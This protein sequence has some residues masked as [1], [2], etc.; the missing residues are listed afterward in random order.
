MTTL[1]STAEAGARLGISARQAQRLVRAGRLER[2]GIDRIDYASVVHLMSQ[3]RGDHHRV[4]DEQTAWAAIA[5][6]SGV[7]TQWLGQAQRSRLKASLRSAAGA[8]LATKLRNR[9]TIH[10][11][12]AHPAAIEHLSAEVIRPGADSEL[13][14]LVAAVG[15]LDGY[16]STL[17]YEDLSRHFRLE[18][19]WYGAITLR[20]TS[21]DI[22]E[23]SRIA[24]AG[25]VL[26]AVDLAG[27]LDVREQSAGVRIL[28]KALGAMRG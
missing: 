16:V 5:L 25:Q 10:R 6:L 21:F 26:A 22:A 11:L 4:W 12:R 2:V 9:A 20:A 18:D 15:R 27:S 8:E 14:G 24:A 17:Q 23:V 3:R 7:R 19:D 1:V 28:D 13:G